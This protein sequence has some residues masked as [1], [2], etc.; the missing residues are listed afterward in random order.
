MKIVKLEDFYFDAGWDVYALLK[1]TTDEGLAG[2]SEFSER[3]GRRGLAGLILSLGGMIIGRDPRAVNEI[4]ALLQSV[5][6]STAGGLTAHAIGAI[7]NAC[8]EI[9]SKALGV[10]VYELFGGALR[11][12]LPV[13][14]SR[15]GVTRALQ[16]SLI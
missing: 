10:P 9:K 14:W 13:Y 5:T 6:R 12:R 8:V 7:L 1:I 4:D 11:R 3:R 15:C 16:A 2:W